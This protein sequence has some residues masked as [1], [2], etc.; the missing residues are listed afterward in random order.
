MMRNYS[1]KYCRD[2]AAR[3]FLEDLEACRYFPKYFTIETCNNCNA[4][5]IMCPKGQKGTKKMEIMEEALYDRIVKELTGYADWIQMVCLNSDGEPLLDKGIGSRIRKLKEAGIRHI[6]IST[7]GQ[8]LTGEMIHQLID[9][10]LDDIRISLDAYYKESY[11]KIRVGLDYD[12]VKQ[13]VLNLIRIRNEKKSPMQIRIRMV[14]LEENKSERSQWLSYW[15]E[16]AGAQD[17]IQLMPM[18]TWSGEIAEER[19]EKIQ[20][21]R[22]KPCVSVFSSFTI[23]YDGTVQL[24]DSDVEQQMLV[25][26]ILTNTIREI[27]Q[28]EKFEDIRCFHANEQRNQIKICQGCD[29]WSRE[30]KEV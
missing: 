12:T 2:L 13:N 24:C 16:Q 23:N 10:G 28:G 20:F 14:E 30:F 17:K 4:H 21:Y 18:H 11:H 25:G 5:C 1:G 9:S 19:E 6:N 26:D 27:W 8:L 29:H 22:D 7:N 3:I 15:K